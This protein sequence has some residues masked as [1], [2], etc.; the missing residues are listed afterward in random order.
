MQ[1]GLDHGDAARCGLDLG[2]RRSAS[3]SSPA[4]G[5]FSERQASEAAAMAVTPPSTSAARGPMVWPTQPTIGPP[6]GVLPMKATE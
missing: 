5:R 4:A 6:T 3:T 2:P 1:L